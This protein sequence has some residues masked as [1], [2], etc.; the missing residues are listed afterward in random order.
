MH[1]QSLLNCH[2]MVFGNYRWAE[3][4]DDFLQKHVASVVIADLEEIVT[5]VCYFSLFRG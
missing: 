4:D 5:Q 3:F 2:S 1:V